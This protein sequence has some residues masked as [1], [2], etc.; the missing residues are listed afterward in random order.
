MTDDASPENLR[1]FLESDDPAM[2]RMGLSMAK[3]A[4][5][6][7]TVKDLERFLKSKDVETV[8]TGVMLADE[9]GIGDEAMEMLCE[10]LGDEDL[11]NIS[12]A[13]ECQPVAEV[14]GNIGDVRAVEP[15]IDAL[16]D[17]SM[18]EDRGGGEDA[19]GAIAKA[20]GKIGDQRAVEPLIDA[21]FY[22]KGWYFPDYGRAEAAWALGEIGNARAVGPL[23]KLWSIT[24]EEEAGAGAIIDYDEIHRARAIDYNIHEALEKIGNPAVALLIQ[25]LRHE[26]VEFLFEEYNDWDLDEAITNGYYNPSDVRSFAAYTLGEIGGTRAVKPLIKALGDDN[27]KVRDAANDALKKL[28]HEVE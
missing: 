10:V 8:K 12:Y 20:L 19:R 15:L 7:I 22:G 28:G 18:M 5:V 27:S 2:V 23:I 24:N 4:G 9:V 21:L 26:D 6:E 1:K 17:E 25:T 14:L 3:G 13:D 11:D 16:G